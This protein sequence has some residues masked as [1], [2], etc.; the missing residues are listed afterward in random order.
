MGDEDD[1]GADI[2]AASLTENIQLPGAVADALQSVG[3][4]PRQAVPEVRA[5]QLWRVVWEE[6]AVL[7]AILESND[8]Y[9]DFAPVTVDTHYADPYTVI[10]A[11]ADSPM[12]VDV[13]VYSSMTTPIP[14]FTLH[15]CLGVFT[16]NAVAEIETMWRACR[17]GRA[18]EMRSGASSADA[19][20][21]EARRGFRRSVTAQLGKIAAADAGLDDRT[22]VGERLP[23]ILK[24]AGI[25]P[26]KLAEIL[27]VPLQNAISIA[28][29]DLPLDDEQAAKLSPMVGG[30]DPEF[31]IRS[32]QPIPE[33]L[34]MALRAPAQFAR[35]RK[36][37]TKNNITYERAARDIACSHAARTA[38]AIK[39][40]ESVDYWNGIL[41]NIGIGEP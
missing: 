22:E 19:D 15:A 14:E 17:S 16:D 39:K 38:G 20:A 37:A 30:G 28:R 8:G 4:L 27:T 34:K 6:I 35:I 18:V 1:F 36:I 5:G 31:L 40:E 13:A 21:L 23:E 11:A 24:R 2:G 7:G 25:G 9:A 29:G 10:V 32:V 12:P 26:S 3:R 33:G 41:D